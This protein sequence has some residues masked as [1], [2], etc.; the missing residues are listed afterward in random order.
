MTIFIPV[1][2]KRNLTSAK[3]IDHLLLTYYQLKSITVILLDK[4]V[5]HLH[6]AL[7]SLVYR[8]KWS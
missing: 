2:I 1:K 5:K 6:C 7:I 3:L 8:A 4:I